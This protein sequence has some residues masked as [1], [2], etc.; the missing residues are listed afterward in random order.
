MYPNSLSASLLPST[1]AGI[2]T[3]S[4]SKETY[5]CAYNRSESCCKKC[6]DSHTGLK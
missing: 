4:M 3:Q 2:Y 5:N 1:E 6:Q